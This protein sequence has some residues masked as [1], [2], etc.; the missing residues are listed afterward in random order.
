MATQGILRLVEGKVYFYNT[1]GMMQKIYYTGGDAVRV[2][3]FDK[4]RESIEV[5]LK[6]G[7]TYI[8]NQAAQIVKR[9]PA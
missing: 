1:S 2:D 3:W 5:L 6:N 7:K 4:D 9:Y 8:I